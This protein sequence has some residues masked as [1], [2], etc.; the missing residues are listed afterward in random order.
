[1]DKARPFEYVYRLPVTTVEELNYAEAVYDRQ[2]LLNETWESYALRK[3]R[4]GE[5]EDEHVK[6]ITR[7][8]EDEEQAR[9]KQQCFLDRANAQGEEQIA[10]REERLRL[11]QEKSAATVAHMMAFQE[12]LHADRVASRHNLYAD[13]DL[14]QKKKFIGE[15]NVVAVEEECLRLSQEAGLVGLS[16]SLFL[17]GDCHRIFCLMKLKDRLQK[18]E[19][20]RRRIEEER[21]RAIEEERRREEQHQKELEEAER[22][23]KESLEQA[24][25]VERKRREEERRAKARSERER[26][27]HYH[28]HQDVAMSEDKPQTLTAVEEVLPTAEMTSLVVEKINMPVSEQKRIV[29][30]FPEGED[31]ISLIR[32]TSSILGA[33]GDT[34]YVMKI[35][36]ALM[37]STVVCQGGCYLEDPQKDGNFH[38]L[39]KT[40][41]EKNALSFSSGKLHG[42]PTGLFEQYVSSRVEYIQNS[43][44]DDRCFLFDTSGE[45]RDE[46]V[47][48]L[49][50][51]LTGLNYAPYV[52]AISRDGENSF[53]PAEMQEA[54][55]VVWE[56]SRMMDSKLEKERKSQ[57][58]QQCVEWLS[59]VTGCENCYISLRDEDGDFMTYV[60]ASPSHRF[61]IGKKHELVDEQGG[62][63]ISFNAC[64]AATVQAD[65]MVFCIDD[66]NDISC[67][68]FQNQKVKRFLEGENTGSLLLGTITGNNSNGECRSLGVVFLDCVGTKRMF[69]ESD[70]GVLRDT[71]QILAKL[72]LNSTNALSLG[73]SLKIEEE[74]QNLNASPILF[75]KSMWSHT[76]DNV[77]RI[78][79]DQ[80]LELARYMHPPP[81]IPLVVQSTIIIALGKKP[82][83]VEQWADARDKVNNDLL[84]KMSSFDP[85]DR[86]R[87]KKAFFIRAEKMLKG[88][89]ARDVLEKG[90]YPT[91]CFFSWTFAAILLRKH[92]DM[93][94]RKSGKE[95]TVSSIEDAAILSADDNNLTNGEFEDY[96]DNDENEGETEEVQ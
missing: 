87:R 59:V 60:A 93:L 28:T 23:R 62:N 56:V 21:E 1:M 8:W 48:F 18:E 34:S 67:I 46:A 65:S 37:N 66:V 50:L 24:K 53:H 10:A 40:I 52:F 44:T 82:S 49:P 69:T 86:K 7:T 80:L 33:V 45:K 6:W 14:L 22:L 73:K 71:V 74:I 68:P 9:V 35:D 72:L 75:L 4:P 12:K 20:E 32:N 47:I 58:C 94:R 26:M 84:N 85:T 25:M 96:L 5:V 11:K 55:K 38:L 30:V 63:G 54:A 15:Q 92:A 41:M 81:I 31:I 78:T 2:V 27:K 88:Y 61:M 42:A 83:S 17:H 89:E 90:S 51:V 76:V 79:P 70:K 43:R 77:G 29:F 91:S 95:I 16:E 19:E 3:N 64:K 36:K 57:L 13:F 39:G